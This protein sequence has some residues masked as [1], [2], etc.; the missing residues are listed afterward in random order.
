MYN[1]QPPFAPDKIKMELMLFE[2]I[3]IKDR[4]DALYHSE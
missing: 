2:G 3:K 1:N 4:A